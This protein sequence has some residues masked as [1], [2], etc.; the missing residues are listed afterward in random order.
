MATDVTIGLPT[1]YVPDAAAARLSSQFRRL[2]APEQDLEGLLA[3]L[4]STARLLPREIVEHVLRL[5]ADPRAPGALLITGMP[6]DPDLPPTPTTPVPATFSP[7]P[8]SR[9]AILLAAI[10]LGEPVA[11]AAEKDGA[12]VQ[13]VFPTPEESEQPSNESS[14]VGLEFHTEL[15]FSRAEPAQCFDVAAPDFV[16][17]LA[18]RSP[19]ERA[20]TTSVIEARELCGLLNPEDV[21][22]LRQPWFQLRAPHSFT[23]D[24]DG[25]RPWSPSL[26]LVRGPEEHPS[27]VF[28]ISCGVRA[29]TPRAQ[30]ALE[31][32]RGACADPAIH[33]AVTLADGDLLV[34]DNHKC[35]HARSAYDARFDG[36]D[37][38]LQR[39]YVRH[40]LRELVSAPGPS[41]RVLA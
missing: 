5:R 6:I 21:D 24:G 22:A 27:L 3:G 10:L 39:S 9:C 19:P 38:W 12:L 17:L 25:S 26:A 1:V 2:P 14:A 18:L 30:E 4:L 28:D 8:V 20:A 41:F 16:L 34:I 36:R 40:S 35:A 32:L 29:G 33:H 13:N 15:T 7:G 23:R 31:A 11:Y 37:R